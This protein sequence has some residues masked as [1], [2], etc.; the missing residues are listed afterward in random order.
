MLSPLGQIFTNMLNVPRRDPS[1]S[2]TDYENGG[3]EW[4]NPEYPTWPLLNNNR[5]KTGQYL[6]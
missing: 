1:D 4:H 6:G 3:D 2:D 5:E